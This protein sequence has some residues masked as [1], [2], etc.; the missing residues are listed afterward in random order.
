MSFLKKVVPALLI[1][2]ALSISVVGP[3]AA[4]AAP[5]EPNK[6]SLNCDSGACRLQVDAES[7][8]VALRNGA[9]LALSLLP[10]NQDGAAV[11]INQDI[12]LAL[13]IGDVKLTDARLMVNLAE[14][15]SIEQLRGTADMP[16]PTFGLLD[17]VRIVTPACAEV[18]QDLGKNLANTGLELD[19]ERSYLFFDVDSAFDVA[20]RTPGNANEFSLGLEPGQ[21][22]RLVIDTEEAVAYLD[23][24]VTLSNIDQVALLGGVLESTGVGAY[25]PDSLPIRERTQFGLS[26]KFSKDLSESYLTLSG[27]YRM[28]GGLIATRLGIEAEPVQLEGEMT[29]SR[30]GVK[31]D[32]VLASSVQP[33]IVFDSGA[34]IQ[35]FVPFPGG[36]EG[37]YA[38]VEANV[39]APIIKVSAGAG[40]E[41][42]EAGYS[43]ERH[44]ATPL[45][46]R[47]L[48]GKVSGDL[49]DVAGTVG[50]VVGKAADGIGSAVIKPRTASGRQWV[51]PP[52]LSGRS[53]AGPPARLAARPSMAGISPET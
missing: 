13:P 24:Q 19:P 6:L 11:A 34:R 10:F 26:G 8:P 39:E 7:L 3:A 29:V 32:G 40:A 30:D 52:A 27:A 49:P 9:N 21:R 33:E 20:G 17:D 1:V 42:G 37:G 14:D 25:V 51:K 31:V 48:E 22:A 28:D 36:Q 44:L 2:T 50:P 46:E 16:F 43:L 23:G 35:A 4:S 38:R 5:P 53:S 47:E 41:V 12:T 45:S 18:G 15:G